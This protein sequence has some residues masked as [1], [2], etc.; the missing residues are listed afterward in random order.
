[1]GL[2]YEA[3]VC[4]AI[5]I[6]NA[7]MNPLQANRITKLMGI[8]N[9]T[10]N[11]ILSRMSAQGE[12]YDTVLKDAQKLGLAEPGPFQRRGR[13]GCRLQAVHHGFPGL[14]CPGTL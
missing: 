4:G 3:S 12:S 9:G 7:L 11:Y 6:I 1:M 13:I 14:P 5:P 10:T 8:I 2:Y